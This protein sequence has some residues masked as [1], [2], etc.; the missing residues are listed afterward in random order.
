MNTE[1]LGVI[2]M[3]ATVLVLAIPLGRYIG[4]I[5]NYENTWLDKIFNPIDHIFYKLSGINPSQEMNWKQ[6]LL[7]LLII[8]A[9]WFVIALFVLSNMIHTAYIVAKQIYDIYNTNNIRILFY[10]D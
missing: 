9:F 10:Y 3:Y 4:K 8:N 5:F 1:I 2:L 6:H 7:A